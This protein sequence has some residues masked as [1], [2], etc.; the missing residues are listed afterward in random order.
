MSYNT[1]INHKQAG[2]VKE[3]I[4]LV[5]CSVFEHMESGIFDL[6]VGR[7]SLQVLAE[8]GR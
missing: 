7:R 3:I 6:Y 4:L 5:T 8:L 2:I 1:V